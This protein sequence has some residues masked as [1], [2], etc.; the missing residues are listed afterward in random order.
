MSNVLTLHTQSNGKHIAK[1]G[2]YGKKEIEA[3]EDP[4]GGNTKEPPSSIPSP[5]A[6]FDLVRTAFARLARTD[7]LT[8]EPN[9]Q[10]LVSECFDVG[11]V[12]FNFDKLKDKIEIIRW[13]K[14]K[15]LDGLINSAYEGHQRYGKALRL[16]IDQDGGGAKAEGGYNL[17]ELDSIYILRYT[18]HRDS[19]IIGG[20]SPSTL[21]F[22]APGNLNFVD[23]QFGNDRLFDRTYCPLHEREVEYQQFWH[24]LSKRPGFA[25]RFPEVADYLRKSLVLLKR[26]NNAAWQKIGNDAEKLPGEAFDKLFENLQSPAGDLVEV[27]PGFRI[28]K[29]RVNAADLDTSE[30]VLRSDKYRLIYPLE[31]YPNRLFPMVLQNNYQ[32]RLLYTKDYWNRDQE[33]PTYVEESE[34]WRE[35]KRRL[36]GQADFYPWLTVSDFL[37]PY[38]IRLVYPINGQRFHDGGLQ[39]DHEITK[40]YLLPL[41]REFFDFFD[42]EDLI[43]GRGEKVSFQLRNGVGDSVKAILTIPLKAGEPPIVLERIYYSSELSSAPRP[44]DQKANKGVVM[45]YQ[46]GLNLM[47]YIRLTNPDIPPIYHVQVV[48]RDIDHFT[49]GHDYTIQFFDHDLNKVLP[50]NP[51]KVRSRKQQ[52][53]AKSATTKYYRL[54]ENFDYI[55]V[56]VGG[57]QGLIIPKFKS[58]TMGNEQFTFAVDFGTTNTHIEY[59][60]AINPS[61]KAFDLTPDDQ[62]IATL[63]DPQFVLRDKSFNET[64]APILADIVPVEWLPDRV[65]KQ[66]RAS[67]PTRTALLDNHP[68][69]TENLFAFQDFNPALLYEKQNIPKETYHVETDLKWSSQAHDDYKERQVRAY[70]ESLLLM[71]RNKVLLN[72]GNLQTVRI[73]WFYPLSMLE[74]RRNFFED[75]WNK[76]TQE[77]LPTKNVPQRIPESTAPYY[78]WDVSAET[79]QAVCVDIGGGTSDVVVFSEGGPSLITSFRF[80]A[81]SIFGDAKKSAKTN[82]FVR[83]YEGKIKPMLEQ[84][85]FNDLKNAYDVIEERQHSEDIVAFFFS[86]RDNRDVQNKVTIDFNEMLAK[87]ESLKIVFLVFYAAI[88][89]HI[90]RLMQARQYEMPITIAFS[91]NGSKVIKILTSKSGPLEQLT[92]LIFEKV[93]QKS[94]ADAGLT[95]R[96]EHNEPKEFTC[97][98][99]LKRSKDLNFSSTDSSKEDEL[100]EK[101]KVVLLGTTDNRFGQKTDKYQTIDKATLASVAEEVQLFVDLLFNLNDEFDFK[102]KFNV[103]TGRLAEYRRVLLNNLHETVA[104]G[105]ARKRRESNPSDP[106]EES[107]FFYPLTVGLN[108]LASEIVSQ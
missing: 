58:I 52:N 77:I 53:L 94:Y 67:F 78:E 76:L 36:P 101:T 40:S 38:I 48:D 79:R 106:V 70:L 27:L 88:I 97:R 14:N 19:G 4:E 11:Q 82:G 10:R 7:T 108:A 32:G 103:S 84:N 24:G 26:E 64:N 99:G 105:F 17:R 83:K 47:P 50:I 80:A 15:H 102:N 39:S 21:F 51:P 54:K 65:G 68:S 56:N 95:I 92:R 87:D 6:R 61:P 62:P 59:Q 90:A 20:T 71:I 55:S 49:F 86:L 45:E 60:T 16:F 37:E 66:E 31:Q 29:G 25:D 85:G 63:H 5:F 23:I 96:I 57:K 89:Y 43:S 13:D 104:D 41:K 91:G 81:N 34:D 69:K 72:R 1:T 107:L 46:F 93:Y 28:R 35:N 22:S 9:D 3:I 75:E 73:V 74:H 100:I 2:E 12:F 44:V 8:G 18:D 33:V 42:V 30:F 98:G